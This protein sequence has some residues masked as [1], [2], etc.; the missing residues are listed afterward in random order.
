MSMEQ[1]I[2]RLEDA[3]KAAVDQRDWLR[4]A[5]WRKMRDTNLELD[6]N[7]DEA[8]AHHERTIKTY[9]NI[10]ATLRAR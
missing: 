8:I 5:E 6:G 10:L 7:V 2:K 1:H 3:I 9:E 4:S